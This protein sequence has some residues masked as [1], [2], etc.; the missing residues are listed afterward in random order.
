VDAISGNTP[1][2]NMRSY[3]ILTMRKGLY[4]S[5]NVFKDEYYFMK[6]N[7]QNIDKLL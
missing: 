2:K 3:A 6:R 5:L 7:N 4:S 1:Q